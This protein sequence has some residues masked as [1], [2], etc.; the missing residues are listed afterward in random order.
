MLRSW[1]RRR[2]ESTKGD[3]MPL[4]EC[5]SDPHGD[6][7]RRSIP[8]PNTRRMRE[9]TTSV[10]TII[11]RTLVKDPDRQRRTSSTLRHP[12]ATAAAPNAII[13]NCLDRCSVSSTQSWKSSC[14]WPNIN[15]TA[16]LLIHGEGWSF[17][18]STNVS[19][20]SSRYPNWSLMIR[21]AVT[22]G[23]SNPHTAV[24]L[25]PPAGDD[26]DASGRL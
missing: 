9:W 22:D 20:S 26:E 24:F 2:S 11:E 5:R 19:R 3:A 21:V 17:T 13:R 14:E 25:P 10:R 8:A 1:G 4:F 16:L 23:M 18:I 12:Q 15:S 6:I 7:F